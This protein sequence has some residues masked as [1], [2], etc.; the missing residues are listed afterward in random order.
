MTTIEIAGSVTAELGESPVWNGAE[1]V[2]YWVDIEGRAVHR[3]DPSSGET[4]STS[5]PGRPGSL[6]MTGTAGRLLVAMEHQLVWLD[7]ESGTTEPWIDLE[8]SGTGNRL[9]DGRTDPAGRFV[10]GSMFADT[11]A[12]RT[13]GRLYQV[14]ADGATSVV[15]D[16]VGISN[17]LAFDPLHG[18]AY[19]ADTPTERIIV[20][21]HDVATGQRSNERLFV[22][23][24]ALPGLPD[25]GCVDA[26]G[27]YWSASVYGSAVIRVTPD[28]RI[29][30]RIDVPAEKP[31]MPAFGGPDL[32]TLFVTTIGVGGTLEAEAPANVDGV[33]A[34]SLLAI[35]AGVQ[36]IPEPAFGGP[37]T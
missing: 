20:W 16:G 17:G 30:R 9:N 25:G 15:R 1:Q 23:Y 35:D 11:A 34:G 18:R 27:C 33:P 14:E 22:D 13:T 36:G 31:S 4:A 32:T 19:F 10:V 21:D 12:G 37:T 8:E 2:L 29:D 5:M 6:A 26:D 7:V 24:S 28:G 3:Y